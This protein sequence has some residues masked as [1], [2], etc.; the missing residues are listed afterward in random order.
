MYWHNP[1]AKDTMMTKAHNKSG[2]GSQKPATGN[3][4]ITP[5]NKQ[6][7]EASS[8]PDSTSKSNLPIA[9]TG[10]SM[11]IQTEKSQ[12][13]QSSKNRKPA[14][15]GTAIQGAKSTQ[16]KEIKATSP[17]QQE[18]ESYNREMRR[19]MQHMGTGPYGA[20]PTDA[21]RDRRQKRSDKRKQQQ[22]EVKKTVVTKGPSTDIKLGRKNT[23]F[24][25]GT[26]ALIILIIVIALVI[27]HP[28]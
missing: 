18:A 9:Q 8:T 11:S 27:R 20:G 14:I 10:P 24:V 4:K 6:R 3:P 12:D 13:K 21:V 23:Y 16:P 1:H 19:R 5:T 17:T 22:E 26:L 15:G 2:T 28:F 7:V 25:L